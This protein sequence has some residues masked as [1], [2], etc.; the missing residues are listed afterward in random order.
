MGE[1]LK[2]QSTCLLNKPESRCHI[3]RYTNNAN[4]IL[5]G[6]STRWFMHQMNAVTRQYGQQNELHAPRMQY[7]CNRPNSDVSQEHQ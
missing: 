6:F 5:W 3:P 2:A 4:I 1:N 7:T